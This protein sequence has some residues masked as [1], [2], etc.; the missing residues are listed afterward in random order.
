MT[1]SLYIN[2]FI[3]FSFVGWI[4]ECIY[5]TIVD[6]RWENR[7]FLFG[8]ICP[9][10]GASII[11]A[12]I[13][14]GHLGILKDGYETPV[15]Q[16]FIITSLM[17]IVIEYSTSLFLEKIFHAV[18]WDYTNVPLNINGRICVPAT[19]GFGIS[20]VFIVKFLL[21][22]VESLP[23]EEY[24]PECEILAFVFVFLLGVDVAITV[25]SLTDMLERIS[26][27]QQNFDKRIQSG[28]KLA[29]Q[30]PAAIASAAKNTAINAGKELSASISSYVKNLS[31]KDRHHLRSIR[32]FRS[33]SYKAVGERIR[34]ALSELRPGSRESDEKAS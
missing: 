17:S 24:M 25:A 21:P 16:I 2:A 27:M 18:W 9:I 20:G 30:G 28:Y 19:L 26:N 34:K 12:M 6:K 8:P 5:C 32:G 1:I 7:G 11:L 23:I 33:V 29:S 13:V 3:L 10:Y 31:I 14:F 15:W 4:Y 22:F